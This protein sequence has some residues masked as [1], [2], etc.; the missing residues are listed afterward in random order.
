M[1]A[2]CDFK[3][4][5][6]ILC[7]DEIDIIEKNI[8]FHKRM[9]VDGFIVTDNNSTDGT[10]DIIEKYYKF[11][12][13]LEIIDEPSDIYYQEDFVDRMIRLA[14]DKYNADWV[15]SSD[16]DEFWFSEEL[17]LKES[18]AC[19]QDCNIQRCRVK[20]GIPND[21]DVFLNNVLFFDRRLYPYEEVIYNLND[22]DVYVTDSKVIVKASDY[23]RIF[24]G[25]HGCRMLSKRQ[26][27][28]SNITVFHYPVRN[29]NHFQRK[30]INGYNHIKN[31]PNKNV[32]T[33]WKSWYENFYVNGKLKELYDFLF[34]G[35]NIEKFKKIGVVS[36]DSRVRNFMKSFSIMERLQQKAEKG[37]QFFQFR[38][39][40]SYLNGKGVPKDA[41][42]AVKW[43]MES[44]KQ[45]NAHAQLRVGEAF[46]NGTGVPKDAEKA[47]K[48][49]MESAKK[50][51]AEARFKVGEAYLRGD[52]VKRDKVESVKWY[53]KS[54]EQGYKHGQFRMGT[55][56]L[57]GDGVKPDKA[58][59]KKWLQKA[60][61]Q[62]NTAAQKI[63]KES[64]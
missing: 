13:I 63:L 42:K 57:R 14:K 44:A 48:W 59:A 26:V 17:N 43:F 35:E 53:R 54:A 16:A 32:G 45:G 52:G 46:L 25:N 30:T 39:G 51:D 27:N 12:I 11:G 58:E 10:R 40:E 23:V 47:V 21:G 33:H 8:L 62:G 20:N 18:I 61:A 4:I 24:M 19:N 5:M 49:F 1:E 28:I 29:Y 38:V 3:L 60:A 41:E 7:K 34:F 37:N 15:I 56:Y 22:D 6:T 2:N 55:A 36:V 9:G 31:H 64:F 50:G